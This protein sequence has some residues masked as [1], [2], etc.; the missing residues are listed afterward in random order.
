MY[1][2]RHEELMPTL[3]LRKNKINFRL[4]CRHARVYKNV[5]SLIFMRSKSDHGWMSA[6]YAIKADA[7]WME[8]SSD[9]SRSKNVLVANEQ[10]YIL[11]TQIE[12]MMP[13]ITLLVGHELIA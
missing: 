13:T 10:L 5:V 2:E 6:H 4:L 8:T 3:P 9:C 11:Y 1:S 7:G 12:S